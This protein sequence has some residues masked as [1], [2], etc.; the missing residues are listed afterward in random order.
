[1]PPPGTKLVAS[2]RQARRDFEILDTVECGL[3]LRGSEVK[4]LRDGKLQLAESHARI[5]DGEAWLV[6]LHIAQYSHSGAADGHRLDR[7]R[8]LLLHRREIER[9]KARI[10]QERLAL[11]PLSVYFK[12]GRAKVELGLGRGRKQYDKRQ[13]VAKRDAERETARSLAARNR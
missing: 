7:D 3:A 4:S 8:K 2:N 1:V 12:D 6:G 10:D 13:A 9:W 11:V 5:I